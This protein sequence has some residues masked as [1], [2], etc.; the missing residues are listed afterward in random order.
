MSPYPK[1]KGP[2]TF[3]FENPQRKGKEDRMLGR[4]KRREKGG[5]KKE[6]VNGWNSAQTRKN[7]FSRKAYQFAL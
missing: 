4:R 5:R 6:W 7:N 3:L 1:K 2:F